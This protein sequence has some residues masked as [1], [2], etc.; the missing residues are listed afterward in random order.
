ME[1]E[2]LQEGTTLPLMYDLY[3]A[4]NANAVGFSSYKNLFFWI[5]G[6][7]GCGVQ[8]FGSCLRKYIENNITNEVENIIL[9]RDSCGRQNK[10]IKITLLL[11]SIL[12]E[13]PHLKTIRLRFLV[14]G[15]TFLRN[16]SDFGDIECKIKKQNKIFSPEDYI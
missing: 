9:L 6:E 3:K 13:L 16:D 2:Y 10:N 14:S 11:K 7:A 1:Q 5:E 12:D 15:H 8:E 4:D